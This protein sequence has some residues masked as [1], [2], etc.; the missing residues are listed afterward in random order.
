MN[1]W[2]VNK[3]LGFKLQG[4]SL[5]I[6]GV[7][8]IGG[9]VAEIAQ[10]FGM[11]V[12][13][14]DLKRNFEIEEKTRAVFFE[15]LD[16]FISEV[17]VLSLHAPLLENTKHI[18][19]EQMIEKMKN[20]SILINTSRGPLINENDLFRALKSGKIAGAGLDVFEFEPKI[21]KGLFKLQNVVMT[22]HIASA[23]EGAREEMAKVVVENISAF[24]ENKELPNEIKNF[25]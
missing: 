16:D 22:P 10:A 5:G 18:L 6:L 8:R 25:D 3:F 9:R 2:Y 11:K 13:Y 23:T 19:N 7:G 17:D 20:S 4:K 14:T 12:F 1:D 15:K 24:F 21:T